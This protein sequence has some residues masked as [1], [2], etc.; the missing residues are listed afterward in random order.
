MQSDSAATGLRCDGGCGYE[1]TGEPRRCPN[2]DFGMLVPDAAP[3][4]RKCPECGSYL[5]YDDG[6]YYCDNDGTMGERRCA[7]ALRR[8]P[9]P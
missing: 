3:E 2:C 6:A 5:A 9:C 4:D 1:D 7:L 8:Y